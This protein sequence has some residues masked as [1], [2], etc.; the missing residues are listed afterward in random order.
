M[1]RFTEAGAFTGADARPL[2]KSAAF[3]G[4]VG[5]E[6]GKELAGLNDAPAIKTAAPV[7]NFR[8]A[9]LTVTSIQRMVCLRGLFQKSSRQTSTIFWRKASRSGDFPIAV[10]FCR[11][12]QTA[13]P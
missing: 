5:P 8:I 3:P 11:R 9:I 13:A 2:R 6:E 1:A 10:S 4:V 12:L 7:N